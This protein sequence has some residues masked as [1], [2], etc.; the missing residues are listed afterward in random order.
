MSRKL[1]QKLGLFWSTITMTLLATG[2]SLMMTYFIA[3]S[4]GTAPTATGLVIGIVIPILIGLVFGFSTLNLVFHLYEVEDK[5]FELST[6][7]ALTGVYN[8]RHF[9]QLAE[10]EWERAKRYQEPF[11][12]VLFDL[13]DFKDVNDTYGHLAGDQAMRVV[14]EICLSEARAVDTFARYGGDEYV[15]LVPNSTQVDLSAFL[16]R[17]RIRLMNTPVRHDGQDISV[18]VS[19]GAAEYRPW[20]GEF[21]DLLMAADRALYQAK[22]DGGNQGVIARD[23]E[24]TEK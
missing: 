11:A 22:R 1:L 7:D 21:D 10:R 18:S 5:L 2:A 24:T 3:W 20:M 13:D 8:R 4:M 16:E 12:I 23:G 19:I 6:Q 9:I 14:S 15:Y 17:V